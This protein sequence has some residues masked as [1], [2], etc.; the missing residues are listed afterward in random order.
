MRLEI[1]CRSGL[2]ISRTKCS[3]NSSLWVSQKGYHLLHHHGNR[4][5]LRTRANSQYHKARHVVPQLLGYLRAGVK[6][7]CSQPQVV[8]PH[9]RGGTTIGCLDRGSRRFPHAR[10]RLAP[11]P[12][13]IAAI[14]SVGR[15]RL[16]KTS[17]APLLSFEKHE[18]AT[19][20]ELL[21]FIF[22]YGRAGTDHEYR[23]GVNGATSGLSFG[24]EPMS[25]C[26]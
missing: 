12:E 9:S 20:P 5:T 1:I 13:R 25:R 11:H 3:Y 15:R 16:R 8:L 17:W 19:A 21:H 23:H 26:R 4:R 7:L 22:K 18:V 6:R 10:D 14:C 24:H 2:S